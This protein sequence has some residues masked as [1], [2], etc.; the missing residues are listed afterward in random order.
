VNLIIDRVYGQETDK[1]FVYDHELEVVDSRRA[2][3]Q[4]IIAIVLPILTGLATIR[5]FLP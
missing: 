1:L 4:A 2:S 3:A 5:G